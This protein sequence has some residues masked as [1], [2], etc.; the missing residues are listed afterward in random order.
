M[1]FKALPTYI[2]LPEVR[3]TLQALEHN[4]DV[5]ASMVGHLHNEV[6]PSQSRKRAILRSV[7][8]KLGKVIGRLEELRDKR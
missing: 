1:H 6:G 4:V 5:I 7:R 3:R 8:I 2:S